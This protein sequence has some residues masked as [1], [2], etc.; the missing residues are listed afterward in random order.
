MHTFARII[1]LIFLVIREDYR[2]PFQTGCANFCI[3]YS[4]SANRFGRILTIVAGLA[5]STEPD[6][7]R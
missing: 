3:S 4:K 5:G 2:G 6:P 7:G 1:L